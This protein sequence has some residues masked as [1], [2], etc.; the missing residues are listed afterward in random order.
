MP[1]YQDFDDFTL[2]ELKAVAKYL[3]LRFHPKIS[4]PSLEALIALHQIK[5]HVYGSQECEEESDHEKV[6]ICEDC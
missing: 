5:C 3:G 6:K 4:R 2:R 1:P